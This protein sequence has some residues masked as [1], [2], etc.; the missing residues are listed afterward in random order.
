MKDSIISSILCVLMGLIVGFS[1]SK[2]YETNVRVTRI[3]QL[4]K[5]QMHVSA[6]KK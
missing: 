1:V 5:N 4:L 6:E 3:E 2:I